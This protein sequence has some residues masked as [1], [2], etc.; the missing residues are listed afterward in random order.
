MDLNF[1][2][3]CGEPCLLHKCAYHL[4]P[5]WYPDFTSSGLQTIEYKDIFPADGKIYSFIDTADIGRNKD[6]LVSMT[7][8]IKDGQY[9]VLDFKKYE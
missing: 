7:F 1:C 9:Y 5:V 8:S 6:F 4:F 2:E 3:D